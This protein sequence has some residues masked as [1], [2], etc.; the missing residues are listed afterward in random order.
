MQKYYGKGV[1]LENS[2]RIIFIYLNE[3]LKY[4]F[5][6][7][8]ERKRRLFQKQRNDVQNVKKFNNQQ[9]ELQNKECK[10]IQG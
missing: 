8:Q 6:R 3:V 5:A 2:K 4:N 9:K 10:I 7:N 1:Y